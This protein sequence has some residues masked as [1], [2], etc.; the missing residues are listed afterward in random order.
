MGVHHGTNHDLLVSKLW[1][2]ENASATKTEMKDVI[3][4]HTALTAADV[5]PLNRAVSVFSGAAKLTFAVVMKIY[6]R[7][8]KQ[9]QQQN[10]QNWVRDAVGGGG[11]GG[12]GAAQALN[13][14]IN[15][16]SQIHFR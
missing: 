1:I 8:V 12:G 13:V 10:K 4:S 9:Q 7:D 15:P 14:G 6:A 16:A 3:T 5:R 2:S 11:S